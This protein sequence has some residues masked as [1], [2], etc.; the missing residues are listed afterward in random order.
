MQ[1]V[2]TICPIASLSVPTLAVT[3]YESF[4]QSIN[5]AFGKYF[6]VEIVLPLVVIVV[7]L[8]VALA[9]YDVHRSKKIKRELLA[10][11]VA[12]FDVQ[13]AKL[14]LRLSSAAILKRVALKTGLQNPDSIMRFSHVFEDSLEKYYESEKI[15]SISDEMLDHISALRKALGFSP[16]PRGIAITSTRQ[17]CSG[18]KCVMRIPGNGTP[19]NGMGYVL[20]S[21]ERQWAITRPDWPPLEVGI[22]VHMEMTRPGD[23]E[24]AFSV[25]VLKDLDE[26]IVLLHTN[27]LHRAQQ[28][29][30]ARINA[31]IPVQATLMEET[32]IGRLLS[33]KIADISGGGLSMALPVE[34]MSDAMLLLSFELP[35]YGSITDLP[36]KVVRVAGI[37]EGDYPKIMHSVAFMGEIFPGHDAIMQYIF[38]KQRENLL[39]R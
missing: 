6:S 23:A 39:I 27:K 1:T 14:D 36:V 17:F 38:K 37:S 28:R 31:N 4:R 2:F 30:W 21:D 22:L 8:V 25:R 34:L 13:A 35:G 11:A 9:A 15:E 5:D 26:E 12:K 32:Q 16:L 3:T 19:L 10:L 33:G 24:Y 29:N 7:L 18:D 20:D